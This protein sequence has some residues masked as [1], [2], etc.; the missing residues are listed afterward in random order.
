MK[1]LLIALPI[2]AL[3]TACGTPS[4]NKLTKNTDLLI[5]VLTDCGNLMKKGKD[6]NK[7][8][9]CKNA[10]EAFEQLDHET[11]TAVGLAASLNMLL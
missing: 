4:V 1:K 7:V 2:A 6:L 10:E 11:R 8:Q 9:K 5:S 3:L